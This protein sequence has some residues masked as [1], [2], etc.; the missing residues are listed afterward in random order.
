MFQHCISSEIVAASVLQCEVIEDCLINTSDHLPI[1]ITLE[2]DRD[3]YLHSEVKMSRVAWQKMS[4]DDIETMYTK[5]LGDRIGMI[6]HMVNEIENMED[7]R[8]FLEQKK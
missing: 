2:M 4:S 3:R 7:G 5:P 6:V 8:I 1:K